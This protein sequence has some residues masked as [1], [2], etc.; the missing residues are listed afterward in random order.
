M[1]SF[2]TIF[3]LGFLLGLFAAPQQTGRDQLNQ[4]RAELIDDHA[5]VA[6]DSIWPKERREIHV[7]WENPENTTQSQRDIVEGAVKHAWGDP[8]GLGFLWAKG[9]C[10]K[11]TYGLRIFVEDSAAQGPHTNCLGGDETKCLGRFLDGLDHGIVLNFT[12]RKWARSCLE[13]VEYCNKAIA[14]HE[15]GHAIGFAHEQNHPKAPGE[16][17]KLKDGP[18]GEL[19]PLTSYDPDSVMNYCNAKFNNDGE[20][21]KWDRNALER[22]YPKDVNGAEYER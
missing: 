20:L 15:F 16:C 7:C 8:S 4:G 6:M 17:Q 19:T 18:N 9:A 12:Y 10:V 13:K 2:L 11:T 14:V 3:S 22:I 21:S 5:L 1:I